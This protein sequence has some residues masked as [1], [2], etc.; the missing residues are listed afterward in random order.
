MTYSA[1]SVHAFWALMRSARPKEFLVRRL[2]QRMERGE[3]DEHEAAAWL[4][5][6]PEAADGK[7]P[8][9]DWPRIF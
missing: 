7:R 5:S 4:A 2:L 3:M 1:E 8:R 6:E 9:A